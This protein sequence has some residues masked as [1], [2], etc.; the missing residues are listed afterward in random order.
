MA[1]WGG[2]RRAGVG[3]WDVDGGRGGKKKV[4]KSI[5]RE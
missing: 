3:V 5:N 2:G 1:E 4:A